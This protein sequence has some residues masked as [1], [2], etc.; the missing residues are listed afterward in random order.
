VLDLAGSGSQFVISAQPTLA[1]MVTDLV[2]VVLLVGV[3][4]GLLVSGHDGRLT[5]TD[6]GLRFV[7]A[8]AVFPGAALWLLGG[9]SG[10]A[11]WVDRYRVVA[12]P[13]AALALGLVA[14][15]LRS[16][17]RL[18]AVAVAG[19]LALTD[20]ADVHGQTRIGW[21][22]ALEWAD[23]R[24]EAGDDAVLALHFSL[25]E[26]ADPALLTDSYWVPY[27]Q[28]PVSYYEVDA[29]V[30]LLPDGTGSAPVAYVADAVA[31]PLT[32]HDTVLLVTRPN[33]GGGDYRTRVGPLL[34]AAGYRVTDVLATHQVVAVEYRRA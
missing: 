16:P 1:G 12:A 17:G 30:V 31:G 34:E 23:E 11:L 2:P 24:A 21:R 32:D 15:R 27:L 7:L 18:V 14:A 28:S 26:T 4:V 5:R 29:P 8:W 22:E 19:L 9:L 20:L 13:G 10:A 6:P 25:V 3:L 33:A